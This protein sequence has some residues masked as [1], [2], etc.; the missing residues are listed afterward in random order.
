MAK[1]LSAVRK[2]SGGSP[3]EKCLECCPIRGEIAGEKGALG[4]C[5]LRWKEKACWGDLV[6]SIVSKKKVGI[7]H[8]DK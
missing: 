3:P 1:L 6:L 2:G 5:D 7:G 4:H 8:R